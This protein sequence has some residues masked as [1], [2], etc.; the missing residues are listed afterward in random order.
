MNQS[1]KPEEMK[2][3]KR[4]RLTAILFFVMLLPLAA[5]ERIDIESVRRAIKRQNA[6]WQA[7]ESW[8]TRLDSAGQRALLGTRPGPRSPQEALER[9]IELPPAAAELPA[10]FDWRNH[11]GDWLTS[12]KNQGNCG[13]CWIFS[14]TAQIESWWKIYNDSPLTE[15]DLSEQHVLSCVATGN[16]EQGGYIEDAL[17][18]AVYYGI[19]DETCFPYAGRDDKLCSESCADWQSRAESIAGWGYITLQEPTVEN[20]KNALMYHPVSASYIVY[21]DFYWYS[22]GVYEYAW[23]QRLTGHAVLIV[24]WNDADSSWTCKN[25]WGPYWGENGY[26]RIKW[27]N[28]G[29]GKYMPFIYDEVLNV[30]PLRVTPSSLAFSGNAGDTLALTLNLENTGSGGVEYTLFNDEVPVYWHASNRHSYDGMSWWCGDSAI[31]G[32]Q[33]HVLQ[34]LDTPVIDLSSTTSPRLSFQ[35]YYVVEEPGGEPPGWDGWDGC[36]VWVSTDG[37]SNFSV[38][39]PT[40]PEY[41]AE[42]LWSFGEATEGWNMGNWIPG[43]VGWLDGWTEADFDLSSFKSSQAVIRFA[44]ASDMGYCTLDDPE[45]IGFLVD[46]IHVYDGGTT[47]F[48]NS[49]DETGGMRVK[50]YGSKPA[51]WL[52]APVSVGRI[53]PLGDVDLSVIANTHGMAAGHYEGRIRIKVNTLASSIITVPVTMDLVETTH[54]K[55]DP[56]ELLL[57]FTLAQNH[58]NPFNAGTRVFFE[59]SSPSSITLA[60]YNTSG[61]RVAVLYQGPCEAGRHE[62]R[63]DGRDVS[64]RAVSSGLYFLRMQTPSQILTR[65]MILLR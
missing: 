16:C 32:Y 26:F 53:G 25:S 2:M 55:E 41:N 6:S 24:G 63:W 22:G 40:A 3:R 5:Q 18:Y 8:V 62:V 13:S 44:F 57:R 54:V 7:G 48:E 28:C 35:V 56:S 10:S 37:G 33:N 58:P 49:A 60:V 11:D 12:V 64:G 1:E 34:Y 38:V 39:R 21:E 27:G 19:P 14:A 45:L 42:S 4:E 29:I 43:W 9:K 61:R 52:R 46:D 23:G 51:G 17:D 36:N 20:I 65:K 47:L 50:G 59:I 30:N 15:I 31:G